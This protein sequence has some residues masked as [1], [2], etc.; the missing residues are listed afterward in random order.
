[1]EVA[2][3]RAT[4]LVLGRDDAGAG[5]GQLLLQTTGLSGEVDQQQ[6]REGCECC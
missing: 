3:E 2:L 6:K 5:L 1:M 4:G